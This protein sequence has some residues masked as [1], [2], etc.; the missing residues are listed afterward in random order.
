M[1]VPLHSDDATG[2]LTVPPGNLETD[3]RAYGIVGGW[4]GEGMPPHPDAPPLEELTDPASTWLALA[5][6]NFLA[7]FQF[8]MVC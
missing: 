1:I 7:K 3:R 8:D 4:D 6:A 2:L 5:R